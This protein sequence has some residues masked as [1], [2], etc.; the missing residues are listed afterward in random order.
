M[1]RT[2][3]DQVEGWVWCRRAF[4]LPGGIDPGQGGQ[5]LAAY[6]P[7]VAEEPFW[8]S[9]VQ[10]HEQLAPPLFRAMLEYVG[11]S[12][13]TPLLKAL[14]RLPFALRLNWYPPTDDGDGPISQAVA[15]GAGR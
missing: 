4:V 15:A 3:P 6:W 12:D 10:A 7:S 5:G 8:R 13:P 11:V 14:A 9:L 1:L 2:D